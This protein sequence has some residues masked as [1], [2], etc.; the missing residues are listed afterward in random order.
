MYVML[1]DLNKAPIGANLKK[2]NLDYKFYVKLRKF[3]GT[4]SKI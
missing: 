3:Y 4:V 1:C 2:V